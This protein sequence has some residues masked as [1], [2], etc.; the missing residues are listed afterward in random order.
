MVAE[1]MGGRQRLGIRD[2]ECDA[3]ERPIV[4]RIEGVVEVDETAL[5]GVDQ[6]RLPIHQRQRLGTDEPGGLPRHRNVKRDHAGAAH[7]LRERRNDLDAGNPGGTDVGVIADDVEA[8]RPRPRRDPPPDP[9]ESDQGQS[10][11][12]KP[13]DRGVLDLPRPQSPDGL[14]ARSS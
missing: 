6:D 12:A 14:P 10:P 2:V 9:L 13:S 8:E 1:R 7:R 4:E 11:A 3:R 5:S